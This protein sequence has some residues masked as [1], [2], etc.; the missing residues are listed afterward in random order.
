MK[1]SLAKIIT[2]ILFITSI[3]IID[4]NGQNTSSYP[5]LITTIDATEK[6][7]AFSRIAQPGK[8]SIFIM[9]AHWCGPCKTLRNSLKAALE[10]NQ[11]DRN[12]VDVYYCLVTKSSNE[13]EQSMLSRP[14][15]RHLQKIDGLINKFPT[16]YILTPTTN[17]YAIV[18]GAKEQEIFGY[19]NDLTLLT[20]QYFNASFV[21]FGPSSTQNT[22][23][24]AQH[25][26]TNRIARPKERTNSSLTRMV[27]TNPTRII[28]Y[29]QSVRDNG[30]TRFVLQLNRP[31]STDLLAAIN[32]NIK[33]FSPSGEYSQIQIEGLPTLDANF[34]RQEQLN[35]MLLF[36]NEDN[37]INLVFKNKD[38]YTYDKFFKSGE[39]SIYFEFMTN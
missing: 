15:Y 8:I 16:T 34:P 25:H 19:I 20:N 14:A 26:N 17:C 10:S 39:Q 23:V 36:S 7:P 18:K 37:T 6:S 28:N 30:N 9:A 38:L 24:N 27:S 22:F 5:D 12:L 32:D 2:L 35:T 11:I 29:S 31:V 13:R 1:K 21:D 4:T 3:N 33:I